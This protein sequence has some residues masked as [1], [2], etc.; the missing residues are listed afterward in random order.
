MTPQVAEQLC[1]LKDDVANATPDDGD[2]PGAQ[3]WAMQVV[4]APDDPD[5]GVIGDDLPLSRSYGGSY[6]WLA[7]VVPSAMSTALSTG[8]PDHGANALQPNH[9]LYRE[10]DYD[11]SVVV[12]HKR[13]A[14]P[15]AKSE[16]AIEVSINAGGEIVFHTTGSDGAAAVD[17]ALAD[18]FPGSW[19]AIT[20]VHPVSRLFILR[21]Y[22]LQSLDTETANERVDPAGT[23]PNVWL[24]RAMAQDAEEWPAPI[25][26]A[27]VEM[28]PVTGLRAVI[29]P[30][31]ISVVTH[32]L[33]M[34]SQ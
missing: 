17:N 10:N 16:R 33:K 4:G 1:R 11:V 28:W 32:Q 34:E 31:V 26:P 18:V 3:G 29:L 22:K 24:R 23:G 12:F 25:N 13:D 7:T 15:S 21:W 30:G 27:G 6:S 2:K 8:T 9:S 14:T 19:V 20:G 5:A